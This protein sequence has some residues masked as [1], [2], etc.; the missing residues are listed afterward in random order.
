MSKYEVK[1]VV[2][3]YGVFEDNEL[4][5]I[6]N[7]HANALKIKEIL[8]TDCDMSKPYVW[9]DQRIAELEEQ[10]KNAIVIPKEL[11]V[12]NKVY[13]IDI[14]EKY[15]HKGKIYSITKELNYEENGFIIWVYC[16][17]DDGLT[18][19]H[20]IEDYGVELFATKEEALAKLEE[21]GGNK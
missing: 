13:F 5:L 17:Y 14:E 9:K 18:Y 11:Q 4:K 16:R 12:G 21:L 8:E 3:D 7:S 1:S 10:L 6:C 15:I 20:P 19:T 2:C